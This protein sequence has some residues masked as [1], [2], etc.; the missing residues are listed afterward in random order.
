[1]ASE[2]GHPH[3]TFSSKT[4]AYQT[5]TPPSNT[6]LGSAHPKNPKL[7]GRTSIPQCG[8][9]HTAPCGLRFATFLTAGSHQLPASAGSRPLTEDGNCVERFFCKKPLIHLCSCPGWKSEKGA[10]CSKT[11][12]TARWSWPNIYKEIAVIAQSSLFFYSAIENLVPAWRPGIPPPICPGTQVWTASQKPQAPGLPGSQPRCTHG[13]GRP[14]P[15]T[16]RPPEQ[17]VRGSK[18]KEQGLTPAAESR[19]AWTPESCGPPTRSHGSEPSRGSKGLCG[20]GTR[21]LPERGAE[22]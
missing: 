9:H 17:A 11:L 4:N 19:A 20:L 13:A 8:P 2:G 5:P 12:S 14:G 3:C 1:M 6:L 10:T 7:A 22:R 16:W 15:T 18:N 21:S